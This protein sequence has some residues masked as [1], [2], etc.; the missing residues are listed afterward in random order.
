[1]GNDFRGR[2]RADAAAFRQRQTARQAIQHTCGIEVSGA[3]RVYDFVNRL[4]SNRLNL[5]GAEQN[6]PFALR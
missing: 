4:C 6:Q 5:T 1:M 2:D 3:G